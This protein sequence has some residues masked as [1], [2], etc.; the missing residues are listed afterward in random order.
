MPP[1]QFNVKPSGLNEIAKVIGAAPITKMFIVVVLERPPGS[2]TL[3]TKVLLPASGER[4]V[5][6]MLPL[7]ATVSQAGPLTL[8]NVSVSLF[9][10]LALVAIVPE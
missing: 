1:D 8:A 10:S 4:G 2:V 6:E 5:P 7:D 9:R 3:T